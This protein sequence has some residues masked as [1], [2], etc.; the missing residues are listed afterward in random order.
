MLSLI[1]RLSLKARERV[2]PLRVHMDLTWRCNERCIHCYLGHQVGEEMR[3]AEI[4]RIL[5]QAAE[6]GAL[7]LVLSG[8]EIMLRRDIFEIVACARERQ[9]DI[10]I[11]S[12]G[13][14]I[15]ESQAE[16]FAGLG[17]R[18]A[19][20]SIYS[21]RPEVHDGITLT[22]GSLK[23]SIAACVALKTR[24]IAVRIN[25]SVMRQNAGDCAGIRQLASDLGI[26]AVFDTRIT[27]C[28][29]G[30]CSPTSLNVAIKD[31][32][33]ILTEFVPAGEAEHEAGAFTPDGHPCGAGHT[34][35]YISPS[36]DVMPCQLYP[37]V[38][39]NLL[40]QS[41]GEIWRSSALAAIRAVRNRDMPVC[42][43]CPNQPVCARCP[44]LAYMEGD[45]LGPSILDCRTAFA[46]TGVSSPVMNPLHG[47]ASPVAPSES[48][49][50]TENL[51]Q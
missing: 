3:T 14:L 37:L 30:D 13:V 10:K 7:F 11:K 1:Q 39:G 36:G 4:E 49:P 18:R 22:P 45:P 12:N 43:A 38:C 33:Q 42:S 25:V 17:V 48:T 15:G 44:A 2:V 29:N 5:D 8:G 31:M 16:R 47:S 46:R 40:S 24:G 21:H 23:R 27:P 51:T 32:P 19:D 6:A 26:E 34:S 20:I 28:V 35:C 9:F 50:A 41:F